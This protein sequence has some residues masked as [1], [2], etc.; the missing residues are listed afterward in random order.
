MLIFTAAL[1]EPITNRIT[2]TVRGTGPDIVLIPGLASSNAVWDAIAKHLEG[3]YRLHIIQVAGFAGA[4]PNANAQGPVVQPT[5]DAINTY[6][7]TNQLTAP[8]VI[9]HSLGGL[10]ALMLASQR[11][12]D[13]SKL[14]IVDSLPFFSVLNGV[15]NVEDAKPRAAA[16]RDT[17]LAQTQKDYAQSQTNVLRFMVKS[18][19]GL[20]TTA[21]WAV[22]SDKSVVARALYELMTID[23]R[24][25]LP[26]I[27]IPVT[28]LYPWDSSTGFPQAMV[29]NLYQ[30]SFA[31]L[32][33]KKLIRIDNSL[34]FIMLDQ[35]DQFLKQVDA[36]LK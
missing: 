35:P 19:E 4:P 14:L 25:Q 13:A 18:P 2:V 31:S 6:I 3:R 7:K 26:Q 9:S 11:P 34:H 27:K 5:V 10:M 20:K 30:K 1:A 24:P 17:I 16:M 21:A 8:K 29:D 36:F 32:P 12:E 28:I 23:M 15:N 33:N 22:A